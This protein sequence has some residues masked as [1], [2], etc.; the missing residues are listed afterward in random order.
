MVRSVE[1]RPCQARTGC[2][3]RALVVISAIGTGDIPVP[4]CWQCQRHVARTFVQAGH[5][6]LLKEVKQ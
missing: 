6:V 1:L 3:N 5:R 4:A 2:G